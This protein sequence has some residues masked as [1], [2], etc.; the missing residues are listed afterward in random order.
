MTL[1][2][3]SPTSTG[4]RPAT[5]S[6]TPRRCRTA[7]ACY[8]LPHAAQAAC[9][10]IPA[11][12]GFDPA[13]IFELFARYRGV[14]HV[15]RADHGEAPGRASRARRA[16]T[17]PGSRPSSTAA[18]RCTSPIWTARMP[19]SAIASPRS[20]A[21]ARAR[22]ASPRSTSARMPMPRIRAIASASPRSARRRLVVEVMVADEDD[23]PL[24]P[25]EIGEV[26]VARR[27]RDARL[28]AQPRGHRRDPSRR[29]AAH[30][31]RRLARRG[32]L[33]DPPRSLQGP[34]HLGRRQHL[35]ARGRGGA[36]A[37][38]RGRRGRR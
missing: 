13:E 21:R 5:P 32:R 22:C 33:P 26:L 17:I 7:P 1:S 10:V 31:R 20:T 15:R 12:G 35:S 2:A 19:C 38:P 37:P 23:R 24:P 18:G 16:P 3:T 28:L 11:S 9:Q 30:R 14:T 36:A 27:Q 4:S 8:I 34:D 25:G 6:S 29:L